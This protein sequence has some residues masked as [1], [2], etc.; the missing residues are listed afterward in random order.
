MLSLLGVVVVI[1]GFAMK[2]EPI[3]IISV[4]AIVT[5]ICGRIPPLEFLEL[6]GKSFTANRTQLVSLVAMVLTGSL[7]RNGL[8]VAGAEL[9]KKVKGLTSSMLIAVWCVLSHLFIIFKIPI[10]GIN[11]YVRPILLPMT[12]GAIK[13]KGYEPTPEHIETIKALYGA[14]QNLSNFF[15][16]CMFPTAAAVLLLQSTIASVGMEVDVMEIVFVELP[17]ALF[18]I[19]I[20]AGQAYIINNK[21]MK[22]YNQPVKASAQE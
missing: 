16:Q 20:N 18:A 5:A 2:L 9:I 11:S 12:I 22:R 1:I 15:G 19:V 14:N 6:I 7:E 21:M 10:G 3:T 13:A 17:V 4:S 8:R